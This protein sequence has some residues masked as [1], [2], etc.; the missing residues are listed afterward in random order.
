MAENNL[1]EIKNV[2]KRRL[3]LELIKNTEQCCMVWSKTLQPAQYTSDKYE[4]DFVITKI[5]SVIYLDLFKNCVRLTTYSSD[6]FDDLVTLYDIIIK[7]EQRA[8][9]DNVRETIKAFQ[10]VPRVCGLYL[11]DYPRGGV[12][13]G[14]TAEESWINKGREGG[15]VAGG[16]APYNQ[17]AY[18]SGGAVVGG[19]AKVRPFNEYPSGGVVVGGSASVTVKTTVGGGVV[20]GGSALFI[21]NMPTSGGVVAAGAADRSYT[22]TPPTSGGVVVGGEAIVTPFYEVTSGGVVAAG[23]AHVAVANDIL[24]YMA[25]SDDLILE[26]MTESY[27]VSTLISGVNNIDEI[28]L[29]STNGYLYWCEYDTGAIRRATT[30]GT[31][32]VTLLTTTSPLGITL[33][34]A[35]GKL[36]YG[37]GTQIRRCDLDGSND[38]L[39]ANTVFQLKRIAVGSDGIVYWTESNNSSTGRVV[40]LSTAGGTPTVVKDSGINNVRGITLDLAN[41]HIYVGIPFYIYRMDTDGSNAFAVDSDVWALP[42]DIS[43][44]LATDLIYVADAGNDIIGYMNKIGT[45][46]T[47]ILNDA[48]NRRGFALTFEG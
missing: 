21:S 22:A 16:H 33:D 25:N 40:K 5:N 27:S 20:A 32:Q 44:D 4:Y 24:M 2:R 42:D 23:T 46:H 35:N 10:S 45:G 30:A 36:Y 39:F 26:R 29:D 38:A 1:V 11:T 37:T 34:L 3:F 18:P 41:G 47:L 19:E 15:V 13:V 28:A 7:I 48:K 17:Y 8:I 6:V 9:K 14:G 43:L 31:G 12:V